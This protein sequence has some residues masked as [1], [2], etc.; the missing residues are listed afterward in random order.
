MNESF[1]MGYGR[2][3]RGGS[4]SRQESNENSREKKESRTA[5]TDVSAETKLR[6]ETRNETQT[7]NALAR[8]VS[9]DS[10]TNQLHKKTRRL[11]V[12]SRV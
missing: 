3:G 5:E 8:V 4:T 10:N 2:Q 1:V 7:N 6:N 9:S 12:G 11:A